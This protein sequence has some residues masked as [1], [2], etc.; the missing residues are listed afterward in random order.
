MGSATFTARPGSEASG[1]FTVVVG[2]EAGQFDL[3]PQG[4]AGPADSELTLLPY[5][6][7]DGQTC[8]DTGFRFSFGSLETLGT[9]PLPIPSDL[10]QGDP[11]VFGSA[12]LTVYSDADR[13]QNDCLATVVAA[14]P[15]QWMP[16][17]VPS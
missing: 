13:E 9:A 7:D 3:V 6:I 1:S 17:L 16:G 12:V 5:V 15:I 14:A 8:A 11:S 2:A 10:T 4:F